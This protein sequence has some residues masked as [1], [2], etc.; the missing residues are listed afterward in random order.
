MEF[1]QI[2]DEKKYADTCIC[3][4]VALQPGDTDTGYPLSLLYARLPCSPTSN[5]H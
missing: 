1:V 3:N 2:Q 5:P 4:A